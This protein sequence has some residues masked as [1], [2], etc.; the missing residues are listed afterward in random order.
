MFIIK[1]DNNKGKNR[2]QVGCIYADLST[3]YHIIVIT[4]YIYIFFLVM[5]SMS[6]YYANHARPAHVE[7]THLAAEKIPL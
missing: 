7:M 5:S 2:I 1:F 4:L 3:V 6:V